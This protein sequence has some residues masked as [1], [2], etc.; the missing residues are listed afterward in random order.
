MN[1][2][3][4]AYLDRRFAETTREF[5]LIRQQSEERFTSLEDQVRRTYVLVED[6]RSDLRAVAEGV[7]TV[8]EKLDR[9]IARVDDDL[10]R[11]RSMARLFEGELS[12]RVGGVEERT[13]RLEGRVGAL[14]ARS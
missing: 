8:N 13:T 12:R 10:E 6:L 11:D 9:S 7:A 3:L 4:I 2:E 1:E 14:E 5:Q